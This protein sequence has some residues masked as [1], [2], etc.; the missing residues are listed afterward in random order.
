MTVPLVPVRPIIAWREER[1]RYRGDS[2]PNFQVCHLIYGDAPRQGQTPLA[3]V[4]RRRKTRRSVWV[5][6]ISPSFSQTW[7]TPEELLHHV[8]RLVDAVERIEWP[9]PSDD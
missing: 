3:M 1:Q 4:N 9:E 7:H 2:S 8:Q 6:E 5:T